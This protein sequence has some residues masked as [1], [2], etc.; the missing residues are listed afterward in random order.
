VKFD[1]RNISVKFASSWLSRSFFADNLLANTASSRLKMLIASPKT[2][3]I[4]VVFW[5]LKFASPRKVIITLS[6]SILF[7]A[8]ALLPLVAVLT[9]CTICCGVRFRSEGSDPASRITS[10]LA[11]RAGTTTLGCHT[12]SLLVVCVITAA[13]L[14]TIGGIAAK[15]GFSRFRKA[16]WITFFRF[17]LIMGALSSS[18]LSRFFNAKLSRNIFAYFSMTLRPA[19]FLFSSNNLTMLF[20]AFSRFSSPFFCDASLLRSRCSS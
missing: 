9:V 16:V 6:L 13:Q 12:A 3:V 7:A 18:L 20:T 17:C 14:R 5:A 11:R 4:Q 1:W 8:I 19:F 2:F 15:E 10:F